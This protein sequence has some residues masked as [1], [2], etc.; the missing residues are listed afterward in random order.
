M[1]YP[2]GWQTFSVKDQIVLSSFADHTVSVT[3][4]QLCLVVGRNGSY[5]NE[6]ACLCSNKTLFTK[7][8]GGLYLA[9]EQ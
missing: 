2:R 1:V 7:T 6:W 4:T 5:A 9:Y 3:V 8:G